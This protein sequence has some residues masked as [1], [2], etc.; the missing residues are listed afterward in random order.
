MTTVP[1]A[2]ISARI[3]RCVVRQEGLRHVSKGSCRV[4][5]ACDILPD[6][7]ERTTKRDHTVSV[8]H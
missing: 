6:V 8:K 1:C 2:G 7:P 3:P 4:K 5:T